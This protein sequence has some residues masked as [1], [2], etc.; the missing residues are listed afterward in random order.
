MHLVQKSSGSNFWQTLAVDLVMER[1]SAGGYWWQAG[2][3]GVL[4]APGSSSPREVLLGRLQHS[5]G[6]NL[7]WLL[8]SKTQR[9]VGQHPVLELPAE[10]YCSD[11]VLQQ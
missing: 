2:A 3:L 9:C 11:A 5:L 1:K 4:G 8:R 6:L 10:Q 7:K